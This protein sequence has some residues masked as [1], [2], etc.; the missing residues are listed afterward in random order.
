[1][2]YCIDIT[3]VHRS[4]VEV[5]AENIAQAFRLVEGNEV[6]DLDSTIDVIYVNN[7]RT[8]VESLF[9]TK[10][11]GIELEL[12]PL[13]KDVVY[14]SFD[15]LRITLDTEANI[16]TNVVLKEHRRTFESGIWFWLD[17]LDEVHTSLEELF[18][19]IDRDGF[20]YAFAAMNILDK[21]HYD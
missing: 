5:E 6:P 17:Y 19:P 12:I 11:L 21:L 16:V 13:D 9:V 15:G 1:M 20:K 10:S 3:E 8:R 14:I 18:G 4:T 7:Q 2:K